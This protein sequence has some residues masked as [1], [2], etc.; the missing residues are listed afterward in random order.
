MEK[1]FAKKLKE[2][3]RDLRGY[4][5]DIAKE[6]ERSISTVSRVLHGEFENELIMKAAAKFRK[7]AL[8][9]KQNKKELLIKQIS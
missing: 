3:R 5:K 9:K 1:D 4:Y 7:I 2:M 6:S 8:K